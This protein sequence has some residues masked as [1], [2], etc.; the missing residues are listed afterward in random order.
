MLEIGLETS[1]TK[2]ELNEMGV[3]IAPV[4]ISAQEI[5]EIRKNQM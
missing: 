5:K 4:S 1:F 3:Q 2:K